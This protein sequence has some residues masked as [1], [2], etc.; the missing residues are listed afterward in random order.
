MTVAGRS[1]TSPD[2]GGCWLPVWLPQSSLVSLTFNGLTLPA[3]GPS[4]LLPGH[5]SSPRT[6][7]PLASPAPPGD[8]GGL[9]T[10][11]DIAARYPHL[12]RW[13]PPEMT[14]RREQPAS[15][16]ITV[17]DHAAHTSCYA[18]STRSTAPRSLGLPGSTRG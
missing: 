9:R 10:T 7:A 13:H 17:S 18:E 12:P 14:V 15:Q 16:P 4:A 11:A 8:L 1:P 6:T 3:A 2:G 5:A